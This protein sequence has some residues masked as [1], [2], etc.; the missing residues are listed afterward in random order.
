MECRAPPLLLNLHI[1]GY[2]KNM[3]PWNTDFNILTPPAPKITYQGKRTSGI[4]RLCNEIWRTFL[5]KQEEE[6]VS[7]AVSQQSMTDIRTVDHTT[8]HYNLDKVIMI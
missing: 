2:G 1:I 7:L 6:H 4:F 5:V 3:K 8:E